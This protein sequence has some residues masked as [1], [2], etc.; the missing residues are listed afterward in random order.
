MTIF[1]C[2]GAMCDK[3]THKCNPQ[4]RPSSCSSIAVDIVVMPRPTVALSNT[5]SAKYPEAL[6]WVIVHMSMHLTVNDISFYTGINRQ[7]V[8]RVL[9]DWRATGLPASTPRLNIRGRNRLLTSEEASVSAM[10]TIIFLLLCQS[11][12]CHWTCE[13]HTGYV[14]G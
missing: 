6:R 3:L 9:R 4:S 8:Y 5:T 13:A 12:V 2:H 14:F 1:S 11:S 10:S 7:L